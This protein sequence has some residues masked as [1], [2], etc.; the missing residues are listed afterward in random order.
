MAKSSNAAAFC[1]QLRVEDEG[2]LG[3]PH[4][5]TVIRKLVVPPGEAVK[6]HEYEHHAP[7]RS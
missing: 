7:V 1:F 2:P 4:R 6:Q 5:S 3:T